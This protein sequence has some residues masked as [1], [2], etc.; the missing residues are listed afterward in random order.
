[1]LHIE[2]TDPAKLDLDRLYDEDE[3]AAAEI[4]T[5]LDEI[6]ND[7]RLLERLTTKKFR[8]PD[9][10]D[11]DVDRFEEL[12]Q[13]GLNLF[14][15]KFWDWEGGLL[16]YRVLYAYDPRNDIYHV[17]AVV[18][19]DHAYNTKHPTVQRVVSQYHELG[20]LTY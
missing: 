14:R 8:S 16:P 10:P 15:L 9:T 3:D 12:W 13:Q 1:M 20:L 2:I 7:Q 18:H 5:A 19:R 11:F 4:E 17:L 6:S